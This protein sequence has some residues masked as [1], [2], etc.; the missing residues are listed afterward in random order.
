M[1]NSAVD[2]PVLG[3]CLLIYLVGER[4]LSPVIEIGQPIRQFFYGLLSPL[5][6][7]DR[8]LVEFHRKVGDK[9]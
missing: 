2:V 3:S 9:R 4:K 7:G 5:M 1:D 8:K 6:G